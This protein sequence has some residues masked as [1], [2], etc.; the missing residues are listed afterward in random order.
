MK[1]LIITEKP[2]VSEIIAHS[3][4]ALEKKRAGRE[5]YYEG[6]YYIVAHAHGH[7]YGI[8][9]PEDYGYSKAYKR[10][11]LPMFPDFKIFNE[12]ED[13]AE[14][15]KLLSGLLNN[16]D[17]DIVICA[18]DAGREGE[19]IFR[20]IYEASHCIKPVKR[21]WCS[22]MTEAAI[23]R[24]LND[25]PDDKDFD[26]LYRAALAREYSDWI[27]GM[28]LSRLYGI[29]DNY[30][31]RVGRVKTPVLSI[32][33]QRE[34]ERDRFVSKIT[35][36]IEIDN[37]ALSEKEFSSE[38]EA[39]A[40]LAGVTSG[41][42]EVIEVTETEKTRNSPGLFSLSGLQREANDVFGFTAKQ[43]LKTAQ[44]LYEKRLI[45]YPRTDCEF[46]SSDMADKFRNIVFSL[47]KLSDYGER[48]QQ[49]T[50]Q[51]ITIGDRIVDD[52]EMS[53][54]DHHAIIPEF[55]KREPVLSDKDKMLYGLIVNRT[56]CAVDKPYRY[57]EN[58]YTIDFGGNSFTMKAII[59]IETGWKKYDVHKEKS[60][61][62]NYS[63][64]DRITVNNA[65]IK[66]C[67]TEKPERYTDS[68]L[69]S[70]MNNI[71]NRISDTELKAAVKGRG[72]GTEATRAEII[73]QL[74]S[75]GYIT[76]D[77]KS[78]VPT[79]FGRR[80]I[81][82]LPS[83]VCS[84]ERTAEWEKRL[85]DIRNGADMN[86]FLAE[87]KDF[88]LSVM[89]YEKS[90]TRVRKPV[91]NGVRKDVRERK[92]VGICPRCGKKV[93]ESEKC[94]YC[95]GGKDSC[96]FVF[97]KKSRFFKDE[98]TPNQAERLINGEH[99]RLTLLTKSGEEYTAECKLEDTGKYVDIKRVPK[100]KVE[101]CRCPR[102]GKP[103]YEG[104]A[105]FYC[106]AGRENCGFTLWKEHFFGEVHID[107]KD[108]KK[109]IE[110]GT[111]ERAGKYY[112]M[113]DMR[114]SVKLEVNNN[115]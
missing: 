104:R 65:H 84:A 54:H 50:E 83:S 12:G 16:E 95:E 26:G 11:E 38:D 112:R 32:I 18:T 10:E 25:L 36:R 42:A 17:I 107:A 23:R 6:L 47:M 64:G 7:L 8:G 72:I 44:T 76:R 53:G 59:P 3:V 106:S 24:C 114:T 109:L 108:A 2:S 1:H 110:G 62:D 60:A 35:Y 68:T 102:C 63:R 31:H 97:L 34:N 82:S 56:L 113:N 5:H 29:M 101:I 46:I 22:S 103:I 45:T 79:D 71:D 86:E 28:N 105:N 92:T 21:L 80:F 67:S 111:I 49:L 69:I 99:I 20:Q 27:I 96:G 88:V 41:T 48:V 40:A 57:K 30:P 15:R 100:E 70:V 66:Q 75:A 61:H 90:P 39:R 52:N 51:G 89:D 93:L 58:V 13:T 14:L 78:I 37:G 81:A 77:G 91:N 94:Y 73:E 4:G 87:V 115:G 9:L 98:I 74:V 85:E 33:A 43:T 19:L 55:V